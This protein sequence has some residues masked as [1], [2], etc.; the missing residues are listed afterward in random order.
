MCGRESDTVVEHDPESQ[1]LQALSSQY[2]MEWVGEF[3]LKHYKHL[4]LFR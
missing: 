4:L 1:V 3:K 2:L